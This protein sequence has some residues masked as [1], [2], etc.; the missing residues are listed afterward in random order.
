MAVALALSRVIDRDGISPLIK[1]WENELAV[2]KDELAEALI[3]AVRARFDMLRYV[4]MGMPG[5]PA[6][7]DAPISTHLDGR[8]RGLAS[9]MLLHRYPP[10]PELADRTVDLK[11][12]DVILIETSDLYRSLIVNPFGLRSIDKLRSIGIFY[13]PREISLGLKHEHGTRN[14]AVRPFFH[15]TI[16][17]VE[18]AG[19]IEWFAGECISIFLEKYR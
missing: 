18:S 10:W 14:M 7:Y 2:V 3:S 1:K 19:Q 4:A 6:G 13:G 11:G 15:P 12:H 5:A 8:K 16:D 17:A 9:R